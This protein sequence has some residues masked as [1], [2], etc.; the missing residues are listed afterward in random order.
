MISPWERLGI[1]PTDDVRAI[2]RAYARCLKHCNPEDDPEGFQE[3]RIAYEYAMRSAQHGATQEEARPAE[4]EPPELWPPSLAAPAGQPGAADPESARWSSSAAGVVV[5][6]AAWIAAA[7][8]RIFAGSDEQHSS[9]VARALWRSPELDNIE[10]RYA[11]ERELLAALLAMPKLPAHFAR[12]CAQHYGWARAATELGPL[13]AELDAFMTRLVDAELRRSV[14]AW[15]ARSGDRAIRAEV[16]GHLFGD[17]MVPVPL[18]WLHNEKHLAA[19]QQLFEDM[20]QHRGLLDALAKPGVRQRARLWKSALRGRVVWRWT[21]RSAIAGAATSLFAFATGR[22]DFVPLAAFWLTIA[23]GLACHRFSLTAGHRF[24]VE[25]PVGARVRDFYLGAQHKERRAKLAYWVGLTLVLAA[26]PRASSAGGL[27]SFLALAVE[28]SAVALLWK[29]LG[30]AR[31]F[32]GILSAIA[33]YGAV[34]RIELRGVVG[35]DPPVVFVATVALRSIVERGAARLFGQR[36]IARVPLPFVIRDAACGVGLSLLAYAA[37]IGLNHDTA[38]Q[39]LILVVGCGLGLFLVLF[40]LAWSAS[41][42]PNA[43]G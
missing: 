30:F 18:A 35:F 10:L 9:D 38:G 19:A 14:E 40:I 24:L 6:P 1:A 12:G 4:R 3:L 34:T 22:S 8:A 17:G 32:G 23:V 11:L 13:V 39:A 15:V 28:V 25:H 16:I 37:D 5:D 33:F 20:A 21:K 42:W 27:D 36:K 43:E 29:A 41:L 2:R 31:W 7:L 26:A